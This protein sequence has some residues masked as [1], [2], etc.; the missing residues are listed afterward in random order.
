MSDE[1]GRGKKRIVIPVSLHNLRS[2]FCL[3]DATS[4]DGDTLCASVY[5][6]F[7]LQTNSDPAS[8]LDGCGLPMPGR[9]QSRR[10]LSLLTF[11]FKF[12]ITWP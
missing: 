5:F 11:I 3:K 1:K 10:F 12:P 7:Y 2:G 4:A 6:G 9:C 8:A